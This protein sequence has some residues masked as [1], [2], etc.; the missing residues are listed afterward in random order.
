MALCVELEQITKVWVS[1]GVNCIPQFRKEKHQY[2]ETD[3]TNLEQI[4]KVWVSGRG[5]KKALPLY[6]SRTQAVD[7]TDWWQVCERPGNLV[8][9]TLRMRDTIYCIHRWQISTLWGIS[10]TSLP[11]QVNSKSCYTLRKLPGMKSHC[12]QL[13]FQYWQKFLPKY[14][15]SF[16]K[17]MNP[18]PQNNPTERQ[19]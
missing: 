5:S 18:P 6:C 1:G 3:R 16:L 19:K 4:T 2:R 11:L 10:C 17:I 9:H 7:R 13:S 8:E 14:L 15:K 12:L